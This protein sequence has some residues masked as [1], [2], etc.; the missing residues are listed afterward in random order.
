MFIFGFGHPVFAPRLICKRYMKKKGRLNGEREEE[1]GSLIKH[2]QASASFPPAYPKMMHQP[3]SSSQRPKERENEQRKKRR[4]S[5]L[6]D[7]YVS[8]CLRDEGG[9]R[10]GRKKKDKK[11]F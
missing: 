1:E 7:S 5:H 9:G 4:R 2:P 10:W 11:G 6:K 3:S 8:V